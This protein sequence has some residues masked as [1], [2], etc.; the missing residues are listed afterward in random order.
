MT[1]NSRTHHNPSEGK[2]LYSVIGCNT[3]MNELREIFGF[4]EEDIQLNL[5][6][7]GKEF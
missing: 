2:Y 3:Q 5:G 4:T 6:L 1:L 7:L